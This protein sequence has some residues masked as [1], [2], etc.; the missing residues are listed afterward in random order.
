MSVSWREG[1]R[2]TAKELDREESKSEESKSEMSQQKVL[3]VHV[4]ITLFINQSATSESK[5]V[6]STNS[7]LMTYQSVLE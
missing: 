6:I 3:Y 4:G 7:A 5:N 2:H 1:P